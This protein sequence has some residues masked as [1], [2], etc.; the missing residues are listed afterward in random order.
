MR[1][2]PSLSRRAQPDRRGAPPLVRGGGFRRGR[3]RRA[4]R[5]RPATRRISTPS[6]PSSIRSDG[7]TRRAL[8]P[9]L[10]GI[11][12]EEAAGGRRGADLRLSPASSAIASTE[13]S[14]SSRN[15]RCSN[16]IG[17]TKP[18]SGSW[19]TALR[20]A[21]VQR[22][23]A[24][25]ADDA[26]LSAGARPIRSRQPERVT[27]AEAFARYA[28]IDLWRR[29]DDRCRRRPRRARRASGGGRHP[30]RRRRHLVRHLQPH[31]RRAD[32][33]ASRHRP[34]D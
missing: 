20:I 8:S 3:S 6:P 22:R 7:S 19:T 10:A 27:V 24:A 21:R 1:R 26:S 13:R 31:P 16:G 4:C 9:H 2:P 32:R 18:T 11:R 14:A 23:E 33:A 25:G 12:A 34:P 15:S 28:G 29:F 5:S 17:R 30:R